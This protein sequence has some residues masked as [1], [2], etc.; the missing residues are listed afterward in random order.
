M[1]TGNA[2]GCWTNYTRSVSS[3]A[4]RN[5][6]EPSASRD[7]KNTHFKGDTA[8][9]WTS[10]PRYLTKQEK[11]HSVSLVKVFDLLA[12]FEGNWSVEIDT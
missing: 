3:M 4:G 7:F 1:W 5:L 10:Q 9:L 11:A 2:G 8:P 12:V 6:S